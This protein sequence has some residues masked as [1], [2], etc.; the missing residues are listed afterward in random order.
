[1]ALGRKF[2]L[3]Y[4]PAEDRIAWDMEDDAGEATRIWITQRMCRQF[5][6][7]LIP[8]LPQPGPQVAAEHRDAVRGFQQAAAMS[9]L[10]DAPPVKPPQSAP[11]GRARAIH[12]APKPAGVGVEFDLGEAGQRAIDLDLAAARQMLTL[13]YGLHAHAG[14]PVDFWPDWI[15]KSA[16]PAA[17]APAMN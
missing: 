11:A 6:G 2:T 16:Q 3:L 9:S 12:L 10:G 14:W 13:L 4:D 5:V 8:R 1:M 15:A 7:A 17:D